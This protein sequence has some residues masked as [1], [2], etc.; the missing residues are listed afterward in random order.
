MASL[1]DIFE[2]KPQCTAELLGDIL[3]TFQPN[4][5]VRQIVQ[6]LQHLHN[7]N[8][9]HRD[10]KPQNILIAREKNGF[11]Y[12]ISDFGLCKR[13]L[14]DQSSFRPTVDNSGGTLGWRAPETVRLF[15]QPTSSDEEFQSVANQVDS[16]QRLTKAVDIFA[17][18]LLTYY[19]VSG[20]DHPFGDRYQREHNII[21]N[22]LEAPKLD[23]LPYEAVDL[24]TRMLCFV[25]NDRPLSDD[26]LQ[27]PFFWDDS[28]RLQFLQDFSDRIDIEDRETS[29]LLVDF[30]RE[31]PELVGSQGWHNLV[32]RAFYNN[33]GKYRKYDS[34]RLQDL[35][36]AIRNKV[37]E[38][39][40]IHLVRLV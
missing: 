24:I 7:H 33:L 22:Q 17:L 11:R 18:G 30:E 10:I 6:G 19:I 37:N 35:L 15:S 21:Q 25:P 38:N 1:F 16:I 34:T 29:T 12:L 4:T 8:I 36:R 27:H 2:N 28:K 39:F 9:V 5:V 31:A 20:G 3:Q 14:D 23:L 26:I 32:H 40:C 13:L